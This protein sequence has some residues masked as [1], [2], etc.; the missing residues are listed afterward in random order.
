MENK[1]N[2]R[3]VGMLGFAMRAGK[4]IIGCDLVCRAL[5]KSGGGRVELVLVSDGASDGT[6]KKITNKC[7]FY[8]TDL[9]EIALG[10]EELGSLLGKSYAPAVIAVCDKGF[11]E[12]I[13]IALGD[14]QISN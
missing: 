12:Q 10:T 13:R 5:S 8:K 11:A 1:T 9:F 14:R 6:K 2:T 7:N 4:I 3:L